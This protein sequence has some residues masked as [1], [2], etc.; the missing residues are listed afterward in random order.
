MTFFELGKNKY[1]REQ[2]TENFQKKQVPIFKKR[3]HVTL[4][5]GNIVQRPVLSVSYIVSLIHKFSYELRHQS[6]KL[7]PL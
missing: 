4:Q 2:E 1:F 7:Q 3:A 5:M 6:Q